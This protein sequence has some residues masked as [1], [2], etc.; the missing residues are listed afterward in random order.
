MAVQW[1]PGHMAKT[2]KLIQEQLKLVDA[3]IE[4]VDARAPESSR[5]PLL[6][7]LVGGRKPRLILLNKEDL[8]D[9]RRTADWVGT[10]QAQ[11]DC[12]AF[13]FCAAAGRKQLIGRLKAALFDLTRQKRERLARRGVR[14]Q[15]VRCMVV[16]IPNVGKSTL[17]NL[18]AGKKAAQTGD[19]P[20]V[21]RGAQ[22][23]RLDADLELLDMPG[24]LW[25]KF[26]DPAVGD[27]LAMTGAIP[28]DVYDA[29]EVALHLLAYLQTHYPAELAARYS[30][31][32][33]A[34]GTE[35]DPAADGPLAV[36]EQIG[37]NRGDLLKG[38]RLDCD[39][40][41]RAVLLDFRQGRI[42]RITLE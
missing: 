28:E 25:P 21:T 14:G 16:G 26:E 40:T 20:G 42:G 30:L 2:K 1:F 36:L 27:R 31:H 10:F 3:V 19:K 6:G 9:P 18:L 37:R 22:W 38:G 12:R 4:M 15:T 8:A 11:A 29:R 41:A 34:G 7:E 13:A 23:V 39:K 24:I 35:P 33:S 17:I 5:N 32:L